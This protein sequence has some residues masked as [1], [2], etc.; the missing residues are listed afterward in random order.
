MKH[1]ENPEKAVAVV[2]D[3]Q[4]PN[5]GTLTQASTAVLRRD[6]NG[7]PQDIDGIGHLACPAC[8]EKLLSAA[9][10]RELQQRA[11]AAYRQRHGLLA[12]AEIRQLR[13]QMALTQAELAHMLQL[14]GNTL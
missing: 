2:H 1:H 3:D 11:I 14:G 9:A 6:I 10:V 13:E 12:A 8:T 7:E 4:C 5:C